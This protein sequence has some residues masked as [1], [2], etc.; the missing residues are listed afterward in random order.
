M[1]FTQMLIGVL[2]AFASCGLRHGVFAGIADF[3][4]MR[5]HASLNSAAAGLNVGTNLLDVSAAR[6]RNCGSLHQHGRQGADT[7]LK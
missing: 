1:L 7:S 3:R 5:F 6:F 2:S 4:E